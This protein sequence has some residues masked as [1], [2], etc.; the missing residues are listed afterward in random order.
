MELFSR[1]DNNIED[2]FVDHP[3][4]EVKRE[5]TSGSYG[6]FFLKRYERRAR[7]KEDSN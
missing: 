2:D 4:K 3:L 5:L 1:V 6:M 7:Q